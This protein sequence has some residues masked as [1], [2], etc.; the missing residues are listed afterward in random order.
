[1]AESAIIHANRDR[2]RL[3]DY[4]RLLSMAEASFLEGSFQ[5][6]YLEAGNLLKKI[7]AQLNQK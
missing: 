2:N 3:T 5:Q 1:L 4:H 7:N 6:S